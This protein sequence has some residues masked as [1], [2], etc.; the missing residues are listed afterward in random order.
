MLALPS[1]SITISTA[2]ATP[3]ETPQTKTKACFILRMDLLAPLYDDINLVKFQQ[4]IL[5]TIMRLFVLL[6]ST[7]GV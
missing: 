2:T 1:S 5:S 7:V 3:G 4:V 6:L